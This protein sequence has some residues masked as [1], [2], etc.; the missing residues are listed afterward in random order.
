M[1]NFIKEKV[2]NHTNNDDDD[3]NNTADNDSNKSEITMQQSQQFHNNNDNNDNN[4]SMKF[5]ANNVDA[6]NKNI[7]K[8]TNKTS[9]NLI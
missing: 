6:S 7:T 2:E 4:I 1:D 9:S 3:S 5:D 8:K